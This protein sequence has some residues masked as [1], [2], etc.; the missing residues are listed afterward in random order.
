M[1]VGKLDYQAAA[2]AIVAADGTATITFNGPPSRTVRDLSSIVVTCSSSSP[3]PTA[4]LYRSS[5]SPNRL[6]ATSRAADADT[7]LPD[8]QADQL[9]SGEPFIIVWSGAT[10][11]A[12]VGAN[13]YGVDSQI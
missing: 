6:M 2:T 1:N 9:K 13:A 3:H 10:V 7:F 4:K 11:G 5:V 12:T 8:G